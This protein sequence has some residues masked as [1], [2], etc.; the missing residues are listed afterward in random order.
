MRIPWGLAVAA[1]VLASST[2][3]RAHGAPSTLEGAPTPAA[4]PGDGATAQALVAEVEAK[5]KG[6]G[7]AVVADSLK[8]ARN[9]LERARGARQ[10]GDVPHARML[11]GLALECA[12]TARDLERAA[13]A[14]S[15]ATSE[16]QKARDLATQVERARTLLEETQAKRGRAAAELERVE[17]D[18]KS[19]AQAA[20]EAELH[21]L[22]KPRKAAP[23]RKDEAPKPAAAPKKKG[24]P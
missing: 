3:A 9:A 5:S 10:S 7:A 4:P 14:E 1:V 19:S 21:R 15:G 8:K 23:K 16:A 12:E 2:G 20:A 18:A 24:S 6:G 13:V 17:A 11:E 22:E